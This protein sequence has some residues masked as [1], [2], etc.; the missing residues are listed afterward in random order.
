MKFSYSKILEYEGRKERFLILFANKM[1]R[2]SMKSI[3]LHRHKEKVEHSNIHWTK[4]WFTF[5]TTRTKFRTIVKNSTIS[6]YI[7]YIYFFTLDIL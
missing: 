7:L 1:K 4:R 2:S 6:I 5:F 3:N